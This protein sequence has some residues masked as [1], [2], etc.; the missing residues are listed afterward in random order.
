MFRRG[1]RYFPVSDLCLRVHM[2]IPEYNVNKTKTRPKQDHGSNMIKRMIGAAKLDTATFE[3]VKH[4]GSAT[5]QATSVVM[6]AALASGIGG[7][8]YFGFYGLVLGILLGIVGWL[9]WAWITY[10]VGTTIL[11]TPETEAN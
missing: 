3:E 4:D 9:L 5:P 1:H 2:S 10:L 6:L 7:I 11:K 8:A